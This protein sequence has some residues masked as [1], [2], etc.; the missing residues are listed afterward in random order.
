MNHKCERHLLLNTIAEQWGICKTAK[1][2]SIK[3]IRL[4]NIKSDFLYRGQYSEFM[5][6]ALNM[7]TQALR[8]R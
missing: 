5:E 1:E 8:Y 3:E 6:F 7:R 2:Y 4:N